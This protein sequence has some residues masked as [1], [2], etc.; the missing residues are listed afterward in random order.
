M[1]GGTETDAATPSVA[2]RMQYQPALDGLRAVAVALVLLFH[3]GQFAPRLAVVKGGFLGVDIFFVISGYLITSL[4]LIEHGNTDRIAMRSFWARRARRLLPAVILTILFV[5]AYSQWLAPAREASRIRGDAIATL[6]YVQNW[7]LIALDTVVR[8]PLN[9]AWS[10]SVEEQWYV[11]WPLALA[12]LLFLTR[13]RAQSLM[14][15]VAGLAFASTVWT[16]M[17]YRSGAGYQRLFYGTDTRAQAL[18]VGAA[19]AFVLRSHSPGRDRT[20]RWL[21]ELAGFAGVFVI[22]AF[23]AS[24]NPGSNDL[25]RGGTLLFA[26]ASAALIAAAVQQDG[27]VLGR[28]LSWRPLRAIGLISYGIYLYHYPVYF[29]LTPARL[30][31]TGWSV[32]IAR[33]AVTGVIAAVSYHF[34]E[35]PIRKRSSGAKQPPKPVAAPAGVS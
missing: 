23:V 5:L 16:Y 13:R 11:I 34:V 15:V 32:V 10:L 6:F 1:P 28:V 25:Y 27:P 9:H 8:T 4:L 21:L 14:Y 33:V 31:M 29:T 12:G 17:L 22:V 35:K 18:L 7:R 3:D 24:S 2:A 20:R 19:L 26:L 30:H